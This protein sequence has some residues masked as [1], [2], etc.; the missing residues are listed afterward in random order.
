VTQILDRAIKAIGGEDKLSKAEGA[1][2]KAKAKISIE[3]N[4]N[5]MSLAGTLRGIDHYRSE[6][7]GDFGGNSFKGISVIKGE[8]GWRKFGEMVMEIEGDA[9]RNEKRIVYL[10]AT[11]MML[12]PLKGKG[13]K[14]ESAAALDVNGKPAAGLKV[15]GP[16]GKESTLYFDKDS[17][18]PV[19]Q[20][21][22]VVGW[23]GEEYTQESTFSEFKDFGGIK[24]PSKLAIKRDGND[25]IQE[26]ITDFKLL[27][28]VPAE[29]FA[30]LK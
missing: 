11:H 8:K 29:T 24:I 12:V 26:E 3:G 17:G 25:F 14:L 4:E 21:A 2:W 22:R 19:R 20:V 18:L 27:D 30:E 7:E 10:A 28:K 1:T 16:D 5:E 9:L 6:F 23:Q 13:F 15:T